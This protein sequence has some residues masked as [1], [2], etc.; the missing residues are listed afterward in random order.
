MFLVI[1]LMHL[2]FLIEIFVFLAKCCGEI[3]FGMLDLSQQQTLAPPD[4]F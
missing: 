1:Q 3:R 4:E 2:N